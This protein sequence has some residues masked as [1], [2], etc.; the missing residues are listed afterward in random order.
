MTKQSLI[1]SGKRLS[2]VSGTGSG[3]EGLS[4]GRHTCPQIQEPGKGLE[5]HGSRERSALW[6][7]GELKNGSLSTITVVLADH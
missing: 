7:S 4:W 1:A 6:V 3:W 5:S 2:A